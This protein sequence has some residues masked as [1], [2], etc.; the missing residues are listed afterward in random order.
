MSKEEQLQKVM[1]IVSKMEI[2]SDE[3][4]KRAKAEIESIPNYSELIQDILNNH[5]KAYTGKT[6]EIKND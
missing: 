6:E 2:S 4:I 1:D 3:E 5:P